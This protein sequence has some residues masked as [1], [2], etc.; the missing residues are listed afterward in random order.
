MIFVLILML[1]IVILVVGGIDILIMVI[2]VKNFVN[3]DMFKGLN[4]VVI[5]FLFGWGLG[6]FG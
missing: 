5:F 4:L 6:Y 2:V 1:I 3:I